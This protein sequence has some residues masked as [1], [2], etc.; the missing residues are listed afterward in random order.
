M[1]YRNNVGG[2]NSW[3]CKQAAGYE[4]LYVATRGINR[5][6]VRIFRKRV[7]YNM[8]SHV[9]LICLSSLPERLLP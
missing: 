6:N 3:Q 9:F 7:P 5:V 2:A 8:G 1:I 4:A